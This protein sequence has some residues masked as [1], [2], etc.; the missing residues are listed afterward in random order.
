MTDWRGQ[1]L[2]LHSDGSLAA[3]GDAHTHAELLVA[4][5]G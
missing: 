5:A 4:L 1:R 3:A 2:T